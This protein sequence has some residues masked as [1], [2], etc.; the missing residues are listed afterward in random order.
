MIDEGDRMGRGR[1]R[2][3]HGL[4]I[5]GFAILGVVGAAI[6]ALAFGWIVMLLWN[7]LMPQI[8]GLGVITYWQAFG[9]VILAKLLFGALGRG[10]HAPGRGRRQA[11]PGPWA[12]DWPHGPGREQK[13]RYYRDFW[14]EEGEEAFEK[15][16]QKRGGEGVT[17]ES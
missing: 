3:L 7:W 15:Y 1:R 9:I 16:V 11:G 2:A 13:W 10:G 6:F 5:A 12:H 4:R 17:R 14:R 8:F